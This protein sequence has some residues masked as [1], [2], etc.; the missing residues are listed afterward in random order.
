MMPIFLSYARADG[1]DAATRLRNELI[2]MGFTVWRDLEEM[3]GG[4]AWKEQLRAALRAVDAV[5]VLLT[6]AAVTSKT[7]E[8]EWQNAL[9]LDKRV[10]PVLIQPCDV[11]AELAR[12]HYH[13][14]NTP[15]VYTLGL[16]RLARDLVQLLVAA[17]SQAT[18]AE[19]ATHTTYRVGK[20]T[21]S[22]I[23]PNATAIN[24]PSGNRTSAAKLVQAL[25]QRKTT[26]P[27]DAKDASYTIDEA[28]VS[29]IGPDAVVYNI[30][31]DRQTAVNKVL[32]E[33]QK[34]THTQIGTTYAAEIQDVLTEIAGQ[35]GALHTQIATLEAKI[36]A[37]FDQ[38]EQTIIAAMV[39]R[40]DEQ[41]AALLD[42]M[43]DAV[44]IG[45]LTAE[46]LAATLKTIEES[47]RPLQQLWLSDR[48]VVK[49][50]GQVIEAIDEPGLDVRHRLKLTIPLIPILLSYESEIE[51]NIHANLET[52]WQQLRNWTKKG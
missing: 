43:L 31:R 51:L 13:H 35:V 5:V 21:Q 37:R 22:A 11:P 10:L 46:E 41:Q 1:L 25:A 34:L 14:L 47:L 15:D 17:E 50:V 4:Q 9:T 30:Q 39:T 16:A 38:N 49:S 27:V 29:A 28:E 12:L 33:L 42:A 2:A 26:Q 52:I 32:D 24:V 19:K 18:T 36:L 40:L 3:R 8:W 48:Q 7:V 45:T 44:E 20:S 23:G 6:P